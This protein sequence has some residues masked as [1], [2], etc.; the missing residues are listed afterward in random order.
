VEFYNQERL[1]HEFEFIGI[2]NPFFKADSEIATGKQFQRGYSV[3]IKQKFYNPR[4]VNM[5]YFGHEIRFTNVGH[6]VNR[7]LNINPDNVFTFNA[8]EQRIQY[9]VMLGYRIMKKN[10]AGGFTIDSFV[11]A[12]IGYRHFDAE[13]RFA[14]FFEELN[15]SKL[16]TTFNVGLNFGNVF[17]FR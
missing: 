12:D 14:S 6:F 15:Q 5:W 17:P 9:G 10:N 2:R 16:A 11:S 13:P 3:A 7:P 4:R 1:G 8:V